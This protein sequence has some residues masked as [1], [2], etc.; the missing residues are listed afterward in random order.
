MNDMYKNFETDPKKEVDGIVLDYETFRV[1]VARAGGANKRF[2]KVLEHH[3]KPLERVIANK[4]LSEKKAKKILK[5][6]YGAAI[7]TNWEVLELETQPIADGDEEPV[8]LEVWKQGIHTKNGDV[9]DFTQA[10]VLMTFEKLPE[11]FNDIKTQ[12]EELANFRKS[13]WDE[14]AKN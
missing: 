3:T 12:A 8:V 9:I 2:T 7:V 14:T 4:M 5:M 6:T 10:N 1:T 11:L 13:L